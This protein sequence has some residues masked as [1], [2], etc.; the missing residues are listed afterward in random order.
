MDKQ[1][2]HQLADLQ[3]VASRAGKGEGPVQGDGRDTRRQADGDDINRHRTINYAQQYQGSY[4]RR[5][6]DSHRPQQHGRVQRDEY[7][8][9]KRR[10]EDDDCRGGRG[11]YPRDDRGRNYRE[12]RSGRG[13]RMPNNDRFD[14]RSG[15]RR[16]DGYSDEI[17][18]Q[19]AQQ[20][21]VPLAELVS[22]VAAQYS[23]AVDDAPSVA[24]ENKQR[25]IALLFLTIDDLP[26]EHIWKAWLESP[27]LGAVD[28]ESGASSADRVTTN[29]GDNRVMVSII[30]HAKH[31]ERITSPWLRQRH[32][33]RFVRSSQVCNEKMESDKDDKQTAESTGQQ[34]QQRQPPKFHSRRPEWGS[35]E[36]T[37]AMIDLLEEG[38]RIGKR[39]E[40]NNAEGDGLKASD[41]TERATSAATALDRQFSYRRYLSSPGHAFPDECS[42]NQP[43]SIQSDEDIPPVDRFIFV[44]ESCLPVVSL[45]E[46]DSALFG[47]RIPRV[48]EKP[49]NNSLTQKRNPYDKSWVNARSSPNNGYSRQLQWDEIRSCD[50]PK[51]LIWKADQWIVLNRAHGEAVASIPVKYL[52]GR[53]LWYAF[54]R[55]R[56]SDEMY[57]PTALS[58]LGIIA[59]P[60]GVKEVDD[61]SCKSEAC[62]GDEIRRRKVTY[63]DWSL[64][65]KNPSS[66]AAQDWAQVL[67]K[68]RGEGCLFARKFVPL[69]LNSQRKK[70]VQVPGNDGIVTVDDWV[71]SMRG[72]SISQ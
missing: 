33:I 37:R 8:D 47:P 4:G 17:R 66:F 38:L 25:H 69:S 22:A 21:Q 2:A 7:S 31:P 5:S 62:A 12:F 26:H 24:T 46:L 23:K 28:A 30:C 65:A 49:G 63:C 32:L 36:I 60:V 35:V 57:F 50:I 68:A 43:P 45:S 19:R 53:S 58:I 67:S 39:R 10:R 14:N 16:R 1:F 41:L 70:N 40:T 48:S 54:R 72:T 42:I 11:N 20:P 27:S 71:S 56:A 34:Q 59:R 18:E 61:D 15:D 55:C 9:R 29:D 44:S 6:Y 13:G 51:H 3:R 64:S 52:N